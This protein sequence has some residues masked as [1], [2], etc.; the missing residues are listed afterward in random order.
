[1]DTR[2]T[3]I[4]VISDHL[5]F[6]T[7]WL[8]VYKVGKQVFSP[9]SGFMQ[10]GTWLL[11]PTK[12]AMLTPT[13]LNIMGTGDLL[14][15]MSTISQQKN[16]NERQQSNIGAAEGTVQKASDMEKQSPEKKMTEDI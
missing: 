16:F 2:Q 3:A 10:Q 12:P 8:K 13:D 1:M 4:M 11:N 6:F 7:I 5:A 9:S 15:L 14:Q